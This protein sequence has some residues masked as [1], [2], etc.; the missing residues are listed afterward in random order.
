MIAASLRLAR[1]ALAAMIIAVSAAASTAQQ[2]PLPTGDVLLT[3]T[4]EITETNKADA[5]V[6]DIE[7]LEDIGTVT[8]TTTTIW[9]EG[10]QTFT[11][12]PLYL[13]TERFGIEDG[14][15]IATAINDY[16]VNI[17]VSDAVEGGPIIAFERNGKPM[18][19]R[20]KGPLWVVY[21]YDSDSSYTTEQVYSRSV[22]QLERIEA[23][24]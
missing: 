10:E 17:P 4:G 20:D 6:L 19:V 21:P 15:L 5:A 7:L 24:Q 12:T 9:T 1:P 11:G 13:I 3:I 23:A 8:F 2:L 22:W 16:A 14:V 18:S